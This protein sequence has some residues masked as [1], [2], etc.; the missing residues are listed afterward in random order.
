MLRNCDLFSIHFRMLFVSTFFYLLM[1][2]KN[3]NWQK[4]N[5]TAIIK[6]IEQSTKK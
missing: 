1:S 4:N 6:K 3:T 5:Q 2:K